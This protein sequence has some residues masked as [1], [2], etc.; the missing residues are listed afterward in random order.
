MYKMS[1]RAKELTQIRTITAEKYLENKI[2]IIFVHIKFTNEDYVLWVKL[3]VYTKIQILKTYVIQQQK[4]VG[5]IVK[6]NILLKI[7]LGN[8]KKANEWIDEDDKSVYIREDLT[9]NLY[10]ESR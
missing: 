3:T 1:S 5:V 8:T 6:Q 9:Y 2:H 7:K 4:K 10:S